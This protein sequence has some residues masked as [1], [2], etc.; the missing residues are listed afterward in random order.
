MKDEKYELIVIGGGPN[1]LACAIEA[2]KMG[3]K[4]LVIE[5]G[6]IPSH[7]QNSMRTP[8]SPIA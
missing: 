4:V 6:T 3:L 5:K 7:P 1:G 2:K 8:Y